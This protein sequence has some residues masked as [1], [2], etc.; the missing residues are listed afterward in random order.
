MEGI[1]SICDKIPALLRENN[2]TYKWITQEDK[3]CID[4]EYYPYFFYI[5]CDAELGW[6]VYLDMKR[7]IVLEH[8]EADELYEKMQRYIEEIN[9]FYYDLDEHIEPKMIV[10][11]NLIEDVLQPYTDIIKETKREK[12]TYTI[13]CK[14]VNHKVSKMKIA[15]SIALDIW[16]LQVENFFEGNNMDDDLFELY[17]EMNRYIQSLNKREDLFFF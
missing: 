9:F 14:K 6:N 4:I 2:L 3:I 16:T 15:Y 17:D 5:K 12:L 11:M 13:I 10:E 1:E 7:E 8:P